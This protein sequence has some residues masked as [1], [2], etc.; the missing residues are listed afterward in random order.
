MS[1][2]TISPVNVINNTSSVWNATTIPVLKNVFARETDTGLFKIGDG[3]NLY[4]ALPYIINAP[5]STFNVGLIKIATSEQ[6]LSGTDTSLAV[7]PAGLSEYVTNSLNTLSGTLLSEIL[8]NNTN[9]SGS[10][11]NLETTVAS[12][13]SLI[14]VLQNEISSETQRALAAEVLLIQKSQIN[15]A[16]GVAPLDNNGQI[17][18]TNLPASVLGSNHYLGQWNASTNTP[19]LTS[20]TAPATTEPNGGYYVVSVAGT[21]T[22]NGISTFAI[23]DWVI[24]NSTLSVWQK[25]DGQANP[26][27]SVVNQQGAVTAAQISTALGLTTPAISNFGTVTGS[28]ADGGSLFTLSGTVLTLESEISTNTNSINT[29]NSE[30]AVL[31]TSVSTNNTSITNISS[32]ISSLQTSVTSGMSGFLDQNFGSTTGALLVRTATVWEELSPG[33]AGTFL[34]S[35]GVGTI[36]TWGTVSSSGT[37][38]SSSTPGAI[39]LVGSGSFTSVSSLVLTGLQSTTYDYILKIMVSSATVAAS[40]LQVAVGS[41]DPTPVYATNTC[42]SNIVGGI[43]ITDSNAAINRFAYIG[44]AGSGTVSELRLTFSDTG[45]YLLMGVNSAQYEL[46]GSCDTLQTFQIGTLKI[47]PTSGV[48]TG[49]Y[50]LYAVEKNITTLPSTIVTNNGINLSGNTLS[51][52]PRP[53]SALAQWPSGAVVQNGTVYLV[54]NAPVSGT[55]NSVD[56][57]TAVGSF[58]AQVQISGTVVSGLGTISVNNTMSNTPAGANTFSIGDKITAV[59]TNASGNPTNA[60]LN[61]NL[62]WSR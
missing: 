9:A 23:G 54:Y 11:L 56:Y 14:T 10:I 40:Y 30:L 28:V 19:A 18:L 49:S 20:S 17:P 32:Q 33:A 60:V 34:E 6:I 27:S 59:I 8:T 7:T 43:I 44:T 38:S 61:L 29:I 42:Y 12:Q 50:R 4:S 39:S 35:Q 31:G 15:S 53:G 48:M 5:A 13:G 21:T 22:L 36:P 52:S 25:L 47:S 45:Q 2:T 46:S 41:T 37:S 16:N 24:W 55:I 57:T 58:N 51:L 3:I 1:E 62:T 26:V